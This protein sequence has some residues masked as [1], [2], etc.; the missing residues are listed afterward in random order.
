MNNIGFLCAM[1]V[2]IIILIFTSFLLSGYIFLISTCYKW[3]R[4]I[5]PFKPHGSKQEKTKFSIIIPA[6]NEAQSI[7]KCL[8]S[9]LDNQYPA[10]LYEVIVVDDYS[11]DQT[12]EI[13]RKLQSEHS[14]IR[15]I[16]LANIA[17]KPLRAYKKKAIETAIGQSGGDWIITTDADCITGKEWLHF[18]DAYIQEKNPVFVAAPVMFINTGSFISIFQ[19]LDFISLQGVT[20]AMVSAGFLSM[21]NGANLAYKKTVF[22]E[23]EGFKGIDHI[24]SGDDM[25]LMNKIQQKFPDK[26]GYI[27]S[28]EMIV[29]TLPMPDWKSFINQRIRW[30]SKSGNYKDKNI[31]QVLFLVYLL[32]LFLFILPF[33]GILFPFVFKYWII[34]L[35]VKILCELP[36]MFKVASFFNCVSLLWWFPLMQ[37]FHIVYTVIAGWLGKFGNYKWKGREMKPPRP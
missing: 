12:V 33:A 15:L 26:T 30:A 17:E 4:K 2:V 31:L 24:A 16:Q 23:V 36:F 8:Q 29:E 37:P 3:F 35:I 6:R 14:N 22:Y 7:G 9:I 21:C 20:A 25:L 18:Y 27:F 1:P 19:S 28:P 13:V 5:N 32:N 11:T 10:A 34:F